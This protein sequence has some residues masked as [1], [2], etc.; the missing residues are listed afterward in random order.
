M[1]AIIG[2][3]EIVS[4]FGDMGGGIRLRSFS[5]SLGVVQSCEMDIVLLIRI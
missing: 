5:C 4:L 1:G 2:S 3:I